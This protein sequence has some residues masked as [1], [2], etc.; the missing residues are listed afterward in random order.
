MDYIPLTWHIYVTLVILMPLHAVL[1]CHNRFCVFM[2][3][4]CGMSMHTEN[5]SQLFVMFCNRFVIRHFLYDIL[6]FCHIFK[7]YDY[8]IF[9]TSTNNDNTI[10]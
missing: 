3:L 2:T 4:F 7:I 1:Q 8:D 6:S 5:L 10:M 9:M